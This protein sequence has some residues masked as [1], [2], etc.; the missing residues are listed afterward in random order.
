MEDSSGA[1][2][3]MDGKDLDKFV[4]LLNDDYLESGLTGQRYEILR[5]KPIKP[6]KDELATT[7]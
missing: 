7:A 4:N 2:I 6:A 1:I 5:K 3:I